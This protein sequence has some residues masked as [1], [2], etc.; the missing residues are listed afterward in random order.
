MII[1]R[2]LEFLCLQSIFEKY[3]NEKE[4]EQYE[5]LNYAYIGNKK[6][7]IFKMI[8]RRNKILTLVE[9]PKTLKSSAASQSLSSDTLSSV[10]K[11]SGKP[12]SLSISFS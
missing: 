1:E 9:S 6:V 8:N 5:K 2:M 12:C 3:V 11:Q 10:S 4:L 7:D